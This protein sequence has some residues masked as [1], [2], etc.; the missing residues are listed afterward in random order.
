MH[1]HVLTIFI[2]SS[3]IPEEDKAV[4]RNHLISSFDEPVHQVID[5]SSHL[6]R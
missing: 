6:L 2:L 1:E 3:A 4:I 5:K